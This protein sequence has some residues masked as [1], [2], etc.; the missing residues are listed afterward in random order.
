MS[1]LKTLREQQR[2]LEVRLKEIEEE[3]KLPMM[4]DPDDNAIEERERALLST[5]FKIE[6]ENLERVSGEIGKHL[7]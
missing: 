3:L 1:D 7:V 6:K 5:L 2:T 4:N